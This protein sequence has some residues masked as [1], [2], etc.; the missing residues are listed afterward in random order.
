MVMVDN[1]TGMEVIGEAECLQ[2][3]GADVIGRLAIVAGG[4]PH[5]VP[6]NY[7]LDGRDI[8]FKTGAGTKLHEAGRSRA[9]FEVDAF[10][11]ERRTGWSVI[12]SGSLEEV[13][14]FDRE[15]LDRLREL[16]VA[17]WA[18]GDKPH[19]MRI[20]ATRITGRRIS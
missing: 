19:W 2:L 18:G 14:T 15:L 8:V 13:T 17:P 6:V 7:V 9:V 10:D 11:R 16:P 1:Q 12:V 3:L 4:S 5:V 20:T